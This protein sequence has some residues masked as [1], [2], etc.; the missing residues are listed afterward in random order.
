MAQKVILVQLVQLVQLEKLDPEVYK[1]QLVHLKDNKDLQDLLVKQGA[2]GPQGPQG[3][4]GTVAT[5]QVTVGFCTGAVGSNASV[6]N[7]G[8]ST[9]GGFKL[10]ITKMQLVLQCYCN[11]HKEQTNGATGPQGPQGSTG[12]VLQLEQYQLVL[13]GSNVIVT[14]SGSTSACYF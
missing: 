8:S 7:S 14:N 4:A 12:T 10:L 2:T 9:T 11:W 3:D 1:E 5:V 6:T 13:A